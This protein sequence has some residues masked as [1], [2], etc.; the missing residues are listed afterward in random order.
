MATATQKKKV[1]KLMHEHKKGHAEERLGEEGVQP[2]AGG[3]HCH[4]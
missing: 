4:V 2:E 1:H 3:R